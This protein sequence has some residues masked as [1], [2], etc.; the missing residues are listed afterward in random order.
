[1]NRLLI[2]VVCLLFSFLSQFIIMFNLKE[3][4]KESSVH[5]KFIAG[6]DKREL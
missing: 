4:E 3:Y 1:M 5:S 2:G 6:S